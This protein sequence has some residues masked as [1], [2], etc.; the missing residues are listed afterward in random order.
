LGSYPQA[1]EATS[2]DLNLPKP[3]GNADLWA[4]ERKIASNGLNYTVNDTGPNSRKVPFVTA[5]EIG[6]TS[7]TSRLAALTDDIGSVRTTVNAM[8]PNG[9]TAGHIGMAWGVYSLS[10]KWSSLWPQ[11]PAPKGD[12]DKIIVMLSDGIFNTTHGIGDT[13]LGI[14]PSTVA[15]PD[16]ALPFKNNNQEESDA[17]FQNVCAMARTEGMTIY[18]VALALDSASETKLGNCVGASGKLYTADSANDLSKAFED[19]A[20]RLGTHRLTS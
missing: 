18:A 12:A 15:N 2:I 7:P 10:D 20:R 1:L 4:A 9:W 16:G 14:D 8:T 5:A 13:G 19:I 11:D 3:G 6:D 17:Y